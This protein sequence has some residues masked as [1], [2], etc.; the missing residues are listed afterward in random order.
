MTTATDAGLDEAPGRPVRAVLALG[1]NLGDRAGT[2]QAAVGDLAGLDGVRVLAVSGVVET[3]PVG[4]P[5]QPDYLNAVLVVETTLSARGLLAGCQTV[6]AGHGRVRT[7]RWGPRT[8]DVDVVDYGGVTAR[9]ADLEL[10]HPRAARRA[11]VV[12]P[13][14]DAD[15]AATLPTAAGP[16]RVVDLLR[17]LDA[18]GVRRR[19]DVA[20]EVP[21]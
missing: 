12:V 9:A 13:W 6:E 16:V 3:D 5:D 1:T 8:L 7:V 10:P 20:L 18:G 15:P 4:D 14:L 19:P 17:D 21:A 11:F 2:L